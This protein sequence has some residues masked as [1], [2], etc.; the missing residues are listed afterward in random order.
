MLCSDGKAS[1]SS[2]SGEISNR[3]PLLQ[4]PHHSLDSHVPSRSASADGVRTALRDQRIEVP[5]LGM[6]CFDVAYGG[7]FYAFVEAE[8][9]DLRL[10]ADDYARLIDCGRRIKHA[11]MANFPI[12]HPFEKDLSFLYGTIFTGPAMELSKSRSSDRMMPSF[13]K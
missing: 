3:F 4:K 5:G 13:P 12:E 1:P 7:A 10:V 11:V 2:R 6:V 9:L 8:T